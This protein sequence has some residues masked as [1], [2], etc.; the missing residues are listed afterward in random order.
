MG[1]KKSTA[2]ATEIK[3]PKIS[4]YRVGVVLPDGLEEFYVE[5]DAFDIDEKMVKFW[6][7]D[8]QSPVAVFSSYAYIT[9][10]KEEKNFSSLPKDFGLVDGFKF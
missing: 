2:K 9:L 8:I 4:K 7:K 6:V 1:K 10:L 3:K 5:C